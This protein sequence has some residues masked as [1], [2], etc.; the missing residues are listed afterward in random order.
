MDLCLGLGF[1]SGAEYLSP[2]KVNVLKPNRFI[3]APK[4]YRL[5]TQPLSL[6]MLHAVGV[7]RL[8]IVGILILGVSGLRVWLE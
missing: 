3:Y 4:G 7:S 2:K 5:P 8:C 6:G 1:T